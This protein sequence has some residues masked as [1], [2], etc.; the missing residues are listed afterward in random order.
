[1]EK[2]AVD[3]ASS[4]QPLIVE[5]DARQSVRVL[6]RIRRDGVPVSLSPSDGR[7]ARSINGRITELHR[8][9]LEI[10][11][12][13]SA[14]CPTTVDAAARWLVQFAVSSDR[15]GFET[16]VESMAEHVGSIS[17]TL[18]RPECV[19]VRQR[20]RFWRANLRTST[21]VTLTPAGDGP[22]ITGAVLNL[23]VDGLACR[24]SRL[25]TAGLKIGDPVTLEFEVEDGVGPLSAGAEIRGKTL[26]ATPDSVIVR[27]QFIP[28]TLSTQDRERIV[29]A[30]CTLPT[31][32]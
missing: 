32:L 17:V 15:F 30:T 11:A 2:S 19:W 14:A 28:T 4:P 22:R 3:E 29:Q 21:A 20:R 31:L 12:D 9:T 6:E 24:L 26:A 23:S 16:Q 10:Q 27:L 13:A 25:D 1:L 8:D 18:R 5:L 7:A